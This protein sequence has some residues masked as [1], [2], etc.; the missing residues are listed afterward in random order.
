MLTKIELANIGPFDGSGVTIELK[1][2]TVVVGANNVGK[3]T[4][5]YAYDVL[6]T[7]RIPSTKFNSYGNP[8]SLL[9]MQNASNVGRILV[10]GA[11]NGKTTTRQVELSRSSAP[12]AERINGA[13]VANG[14]LNSIPPVRIT[15]G[16]LGADHST[17]LEMFHSFLENTVLLLS[18]REF[19]KQNMLVG[20][21]TRTISSDGSN[22]IQFLLERW[23]DR[24]DKWGE[25]ESWLKKIDPQLT[26]LK[27]PLRNQIASIETERSYPEGKTSINVSQQGSGIQRLIQIISALV[28]SA[29]N[30]LIIIEEP[31]MNLHKKAQEVLADLINKAVQSWKKQVIIT[32]HSWDFLLPYMHDLGV[33][34]QAR[35][36]SIQIQKENFTLVELLNENNRITVKNDVSFKKFSDFK[37]EMKNIF[38]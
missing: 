8:L 28:F 3:S 38:G 13:I 5:I 22:I 15:A 25:A 27:T 20:S 29:E 31:E 16:N 24:D 7:G 21:S 37:T 14:Q 26:L 30:T 1:P 36:N 32:T 4:I 6:S 18:N 35:G 34:E 19:I 11:F 10:T 12:I 23:T 2:L 9:Y 17:S 33:L